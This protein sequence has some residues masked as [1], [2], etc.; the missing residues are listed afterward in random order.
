MI[1]VSGRGFG[2]KLFTKQGPLNLTSLNAHWHKGSRNRK[3]ASVERK[4]RV[5]LGKVGLDSHDR[6]IKIVARFL[7]DAGMEVIYIGLRTTVKELVSAA[8]Q[9][10]VDVVGLSFLAGD[11]MILVPKVL[12]GLKAK[13]KND[14]LVVVG[15]IIPKKHMPDLLA[16]GVAKVFLPG[17][18]PTEIIECIQAHV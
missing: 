5:L 2:G 9:E 18:P 12:T 6:G 7:R 3:G 14:V 11:H 15:G 1:E 17:T 16:L 8:V 10:D 13:G 4:I